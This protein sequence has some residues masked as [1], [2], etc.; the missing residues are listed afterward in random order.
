MLI[1][2]G[3]W[4]PDTPDNDAGTAPEAIGAVPGYGGA[5][6]PQSGLNTFSTSLAS[7]CLGAFACKSSSGTGYWFSGDATKLY[8]L[9][10]LTWSSVSAVGG[11]SV[12]S[13]GLWSFEQYGDSVYAVD[14]NDGL[15]VYTLG[16]GGVFSAVAGAPGGRDLFVVSNFLC[17]LNTVDAGTPNPQR[18]R[19]SGLDQ[20][21]SWTVDSVTQADFQDLLGNGG[22][23]MAAAVGL[24]GADAAI[25]Q[26]R[27]VWRMTYVGLPLI[28]EFAQAE[29]VRGTPAPNS[30]I[31]IGGLT[32]YLAENGFAVFDGNAS[33]PIGV[34][35][36]DRWFAA[37]AN[38]AYLHKISGSGL[39][40]RPPARTRT[41]TRSSS[42][43]TQR[44]VGPCSSSA[45]NCSGRP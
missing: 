14:H 10:S 21:L 28:F 4:T 37:D 42:T 20:P 38:P 3:P 44:K 1:P 2:F 30:L 27:A 7:T 9:D 16:A 22:Q 35:K 33:Q 15:N 26:Q 13:D 6:E 17:M 31:T 45:S 12:S 18:V 24:V 32:Y 41:P 43:T 8:K 34:G 39:T 23:N 11:Y 5:Y 29:G 19:W 40:S 36:I 25:F